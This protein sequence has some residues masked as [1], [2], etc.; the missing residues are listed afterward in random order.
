MRVAL[1][2]YRGNPRCGGQGV[3]VR[4]LSR[5][6]VR[7]GH[8]VEVFSGQPYPE[9]DEGVVLT[10]VPSLDLYRE[11]DPFRTPG[12]AE[13]RDLV[14]AL[15]YAIMVCGGFPE[16]L[17]FSL[18]AARLMRERAGDFDVIHDNQTLGTGILSIQ[19]LGTP[20]VTTIHH[21]ITVD[22]RV[23]LAAATTARKR[24]SLLRWYGF[25]RMQG[26][27]ARALHH[28]VTVSRSSA[29]DI[30]RDFQVAPE[31]LHVIPVGVDTTTF[32]PRTEPR[33]PGRLVAV[34][35]SDTPMKGVGVLLDAVAKLRT[36]RDVRLVLITKPTPG[37]SAAR[38]IE[39]L[40]L[41][42]AVRFASD[43]DHSQ[44]AAL[45]ASAEVAVVPS[46]YE[47]FSLPAIEAMACGTPLVATRTGALPE[48]VGSDGTAALLVPPGDA[49][50]L[51]AA[52]DRL[53]GDPAERERMGAAGRLRVQERFTWRAV[54]EQTASYYAD[55]AC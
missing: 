14:D 22:R 52:V 46:L 5:E 43:L 27:V 9:L 55:V 38:E 1:L 3:Y 29:A 10:R 32:Q 20:L 2:T 17:T 12:L 54:A 6:L 42:D 18:R 31:R 30:V 41:G 51:A 47:G 44:V 37:G 11:P 40:G 4:N 48:V 39:A 53:L 8:E 35:S 24:R 21:P 36:T 50:A 23:D 45:L 34:A 49:D 15:E 28:I 25:L 33:E 13:F 16:P 26:R 7:L 19:S